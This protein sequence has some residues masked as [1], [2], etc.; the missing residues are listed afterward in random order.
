MAVPADDAVLKAGAD[1]ARPCLV[2]HQKQVVDRFEH[3]RGLEWRSWFS[4]KETA[5]VA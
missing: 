5:D 2:M 3:G 4:E 1:L